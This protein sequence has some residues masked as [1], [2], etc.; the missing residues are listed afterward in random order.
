M[1]N[2][3][4]TQVCNRFQ[5]ASAVNATHLLQWKF[6]CKCDWQLKTHIFS[7]WKTFLWCHDWK[8]KLH[9]VKYQC[10]SQRKSF[11]RHWLKHLHMNLH[12]GIFSSTFLLPLYGSKYSI[13]NW[14]LKLN[15]LPQ[16]IFH[17]TYE[18]NCSKCKFSEICVLDSV[19]K[20]NK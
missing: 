1:K 9:H 13:F 19:W 5:N 12:S 15:R 4:C 11:N 7:I 8:A 14:I 18:S 10:I 20:I 6:V 2:Q 3:I 16:W 17:T